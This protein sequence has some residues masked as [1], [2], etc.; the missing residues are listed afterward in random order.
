MS[1]IGNDIINAV[2]IVANNVVNNLAIDKTIVCNISSYNEKDNS[3]LVSNEQIKFK[4]Y[5]DSEE[6]FEIGDQVNVLIPSGNYAAE[7]KMITG[8]Y[9]KKE[10]PEYTDSFEDLVIV[11]EQENNSNFVEFFKNY[12]DIYLLDKNKIEGFYSSSYERTFYPFE[13]MKPKYYGPILENKDD[14]FTVLK[15]SC[16]IEKT[17][18]EEFPFSVDLSL[19]NNNNFNL[20]FNSYEMKGNPYIANEGFFCQ[21]KVFIL[22]PD[23][24][25]FS[26][27]SL[28]F[29]VNFSIDTSLD[30]DLL[31]CLKIKKLKISLGYR[32]QDI[33]EDKIIYKKSQFKTYEHITEVI[34]NS[35]EIILYLIKKNENGKYIYYKD[36]LPEDFSFSADLGYSFRNNNSN[37]DDVI[38]NNWKWE[39]KESRASLFYLIYSSSI[40]N[41]TINKIGTLNEGKF[42]IPKYDSQLFSNEFKVINTQQK[43][44]TSIGLK[45]NNDNNSFYYW[46]IKSIEASKIFSDK[47]FITLDDED[48]KNGYYL[49]G[50][51]TK[52]VRDSDS[53][54]TTIT[55]IEYCQLINN[56]DEKK[57]RIISFHYAD[58]IKN[59]VSKIRFFTNSLQIGLESGFTIT[60]IN[61]LWDNLEDSINRTI[62]VGNNNVP[63]FEE[64]SEIGFPLD[65]SN[66]IEEII[67]DKAIQEIKFTI[68]QTYD[69]KEIKPQTLV[70][71]LLDSNNSL[72][73]SSWITINFFYKDGIS[74]LF[75]RPEKEDGIISDFERASFEDEAKD[76][77]FFEVFDKYTLEPINL[78]TYFKKSDNL[79][80]YQFCQYGIGG[81]ASTILINNKIK[82]K[83]LS[84][85]NNKIIGK[86]IFN[87]NEE[88]KNIYN[89]TV[90]EISI[91]GNSEFEIEKVNIKKYIPILLPLSEENKELEK[92]I[93]YRNNEVKKRNIGLFFE[94]ENKQLDSFQNIIYQTNEGSFNIERETLIQLNIDNIPEEY[95]WTI[96]IDKSP[97][98]YKESPDMIK[99]NIPFINEKNNDYLNYIFYPFFKDYNDDIKKD[100]LILNSASPRIFRYNKTCM[101]IYKED[102][103][104]PI[105]SIPLYIIPYT[106]KGVLE[107]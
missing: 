15:L 78:E 99:D 41:N 86:L 90:L 46:S 63:T 79:L 40:S 7:R 64:Y 53:L 101:I 103:K 97:T 107:Q 13:I 47:F 105:Y 9:S 54:T 32:Q 1:G 84:F 91:I 43:K 12:E 80:T 66:N 87:K 67:I 35:Y 93:I 17:S 73:Y 61:F 42:W 81:D 38:N 27:D 19:E 22:K 72:L 56:Q 33:L 51:K 21:E 59:Q 28:K 29:L 102:P 83:N 45:F 74:L 76:L 3:Y 77:I 8:A 68:A 69:K 106:E 82:L 25:D 88:E 50:L 14:Y 10:Q 65:L 18:D 60:P 62:P 55:N 48:Y 44:I 34:F 85:D 52:P 37:I 71:E 20:S 2:E 89:Y 11:C 57:E 36:I 31:K 96:Y 5:S 49:H 75:K 4:A 23:D 39:T 104:N 58:E 30:K 92:I 100:V 70:C 98:I 94:G 95:N 24:I 16:W 6:T 26:L